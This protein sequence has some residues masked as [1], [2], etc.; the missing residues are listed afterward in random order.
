MPKAK[1]AA[2]K[3]IALDSSLADAYASL[4]LVTWSYEWNW[5]EAQTS[6]QKAISLA[7]GSAAAHH[8][9]ALYL[10]S[11]AVLTLIALLACKETRHQTLY[12][13]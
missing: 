12:D 11:M 7:P 3:A 13:V 5:D 1:E 6:C 4:A 9:Y 2:L 10:A 8:L